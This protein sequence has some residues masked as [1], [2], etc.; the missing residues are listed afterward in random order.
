MVTFVHVKV[1]K[2]L[3]FAKLGLTRFKDHK[4]SENM[5]KGIFRCA[6]SGLNI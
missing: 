6:K 1:L 3:L 5:D 2:L 4:R